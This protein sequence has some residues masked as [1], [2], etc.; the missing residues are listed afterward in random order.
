MNNPNVLEMDFYN[1][2]IYLYLFHQD[3]ESLI[4]ERFS[5][6]DELGSLWVDGQRSDYHV[7]LFLQQLSDHSIPLALFGAI[8]LSTDNSLLQNT[9]SKI[10]IQLP[11]TIIWLHFYLRCQYFHY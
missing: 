8:H 11:G 2:L 5:E 3:G 9:H 10:Q 4:L 1:V 7:S 6:V